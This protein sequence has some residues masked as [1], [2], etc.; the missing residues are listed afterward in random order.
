[1]PA[2]SSFAAEEHAALSFDEDGAQVD[3]ESSDEEY[4]AGGREEMVPLPDDLAPE[5]DWQTPENSPIFDDALAAG[6]VGDASA[7]PG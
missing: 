5:A 6:G 3:L 4:A 2:A 1:M 7:Q